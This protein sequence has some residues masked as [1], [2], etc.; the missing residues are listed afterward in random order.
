MNF[1][2]IFHWQD[3]FLAPVLAIGSVTIAFIAYYFVTI[4]PKMESLIKGEYEGKKGEVRWI[5]FQRVWGGVVLGATALLVPVI[6]LG[7]SPFEYGMS[8]RISGE[9]ALLI[10]GMGALIVV[11]NLIR[12]GKPANLV[13]YPQIR[14]SQWDFKLLL[15]SSFGWLVYLLGYELMFRGFLLYGCIESMG[16]W[17]AIAINCAIYS[18]AHF[19]KGIG[20]TVGAIPFG[21][22]ICVVTLYTG[23][24]MTAFIVHCFLAISNQTIAMFAHPDIEYVKRRY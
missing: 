2:Q 20:E 18:L 15:L 11:I 17:P 23:N 13:H 22:F 19:F 4:S 7:K 3:G 5:V 10:L 6:G 1:E 9:T 8:F 12:A 24:F 21:I 16:I 14:A